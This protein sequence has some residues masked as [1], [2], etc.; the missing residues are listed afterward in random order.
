VFTQFWQDLLSSAERELVAIRCDC[1]YDAEQKRAYFNEFAPT[2]DAVVFTT[3]HESSLVMDIGMQ[4]AQRMFK[5]AM[6]R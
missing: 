1:F 4:S 6:Q 2:P 5:L 3:T